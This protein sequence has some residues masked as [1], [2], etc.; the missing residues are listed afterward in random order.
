MTLE[1]YR[2][3]TACIGEIE[4]RFENAFRF[5]YDEAH[6][7]T[8]TLPKLATEAARKMCPRENLER[9][10]QW[11]SGVRVWIWRDDGEFLGSVIVQL[12]LDPRLEA[13]DDTIERKEYA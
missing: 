11:L 8:P 1:L 10:Y 7:G 6:H 2:H 9:Q 4:P 5:V 3:V 12:H 13:L